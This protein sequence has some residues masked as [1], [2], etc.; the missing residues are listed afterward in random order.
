M[1][2]KRGQIYSQTF[3][4]FLIVIVAVM[5]LI[6]GY[7]LLANFK[8]KSCD[9]Q[10]TDFKVKLEESIKSTATQKGAVKGLKVSSPCGIDRIL[11]ID[12]SK[13]VVFDS[14]EKFP[15]ITDMIYSGGRDNVFFIK[16][17][18]VIKSDYAGD[19]NLKMPYFLCTKADMTSINLMIE[20][21]GEDVIISKK[22]DEFDCT[23]DYVITL[24]LTEEDISDVFDG[25]VEAIANDT[26]REKIGNID[27]K[28]LVDPVEANLTRTVEI[29]K[30]TTTVTIKKTNGVFQYYE[31]IPKCIIEDLQ[32]AED[33]GIISFNPEIDLNVS[34]DPLIM[35][36]FDND[37]YEEITYTINEAIT[38]SCLRGQ[39][40]GLFGIG[41]TELSFNDSV[42]DLVGGWLDTEYNAENLTDDYEDEIYNAPEEQYEE[43]ARDLVSEKVTITDEN[44]KELLIKRMVMNQKAIQKRNKREIR[45]IKEID[46]TY[47]EKKE[48]REA[49]RI[50]NNL[51]KLKEKEE[52]TDEELQDIKDKINEL[53]NYVIDHR[54]DLAADVIDNE[55]KNNLSA[56]ISPLESRGVNKKVL[57]ELRKN[58]IKDIY[59]NAKKRKAC[60][61]DETK[62]CGTNV[63]K[64]RYGKKACVDGNWGPCEHSIEPV[65]EIC[66]DNIDNDCDGETDEGCGVCTA[67]TTQ[68][69][70]CGNC[71]TQSRTCQANNQWGDWSDC[72]GQ[73]TC[74]PTTT[75]SQ[76]CGLGGTQSR[77]CSSSCEWNSWG[78]CIGQ[79]MCNQGETQSQSCGNCG[80]QTRDCQSDNQWSF[81]SSCTG[82]GACTQGEQQSQSCGLGGTQSRACSSSCEWNSWGICT[83]QGLCLP[84]AKRYQ[85]CGNCG[86]QTKTC[87]LSFQWNN[88]E[89]CIGQG[90]CY[91]EAIESQSCG[92]GGTQSRICSSHCSWETWSTCAGQGVCYP[93]ATDSQ[94][95]GNCGVQTKTCQSDYQW[96]SW[97]Y[98]TGQGICSQGEQQSQN[99]GYG[100][101]QSRICS[102]YCTWGSWSTC[103]GQGVCNPG[104]TQSNS[105]G[106]NVGEC[107]SGTQT[108][109]CNSNY[110]WGSLGICGGAYV[111]PST[112]ICDGKDNDCDG[113]IDEGATNCGGIKAC[114][115]YDWECVNIGE[116]WTTIDCSSLKGYDSSQNR[117]KDIS[118]WDNYCKTNYQSDYAC[119]TGT[120]GPAYCYSGFKA[121]GAS[122]GTNMQCDRSGNCVQKTA[123]KMIRCSSKVPYT[124]AAY[125]GIWYPS[126][127]P[128]KPISDYCGKWDTNCVGEC[129]K[130]G[131]ALSADGWVDVK[132]NSKCGWWGKL[133]GK[134]RCG[135][136]YNKWQ[137]C[138]VTTCPAATVKEEEK[139]CS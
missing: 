132:D 90:M 110:Q 36:N 20:G 130:D 21:T 10:Y 109:T 116:T 41:L 124:Q 75:E 49:K 96:G 93:G 94:S 18:N 137:D 115:S 32:A 111:G 105:C 37:E 62:Q 92:L 54:D 80:T 9:S 19:I 136:V 77:A 138:G 31:N 52:I 14:L 81:W 48:K 68:S 127:I 74:I 134:F 89:D 100:G 35:W 25:I 107:N 60:D 30:D 79:G 29:G 58:A 24:E 120:S 28:Y 76:S 59:T 4:Y 85:S 38:P 86:T 13:E 82:E 88:W 39:S 97:S 55:I 106:S 102:S 87:K 125:D 72:T 46:K 121:E 1:C 40:P 69:Q 64:C 129:K 43:K 104:T 108:R 16:N 50:E 63:G 131:G 70:S 113:T 114:P 112:E 123:Q 56:I 8:E 83:G 135:C 2:K 101:T 91:P 33:A 73:G 57:K 71:G 23:F 122:C 42:N 95:C 118:Y 128:Y 103:A 6:F 126:Y 51:N 3:L 17:G 26:L 34:N 133:N 12:H 98:C 44:E 117:I 66:G 53:N 67:G 11:F 47:R 45:H 61:K 7:N 78:L 15:L 5:I 22:D 65:P 119:C 27:A 84:G 99:C 139:D